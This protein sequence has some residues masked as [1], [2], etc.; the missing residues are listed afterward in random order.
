[1]VEDFRPLLTEL[2]RQGSNLNQI[3]RRLNS[4]EPVGESLTI[5]LKNCNTVY[6]AVFDAAKRL[7]GL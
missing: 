4:G 7:G 5:V 2:K 6:K 3:A 1:M